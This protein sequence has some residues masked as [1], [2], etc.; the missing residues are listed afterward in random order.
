MIIEE[1]MG[2]PFPSMHCMCEECR[3]VVAPATAQDKLIAQL[4]HRFETQRKAISKGCGSTWDMLQCD[5]QIEL[6]DTAL[7]ANAQA[8]PVVSEGWP[9][10]TKE[11]SDIGW[12]LDYVFL[13]KVTKLAGSR[14]DSTTSMEATE[15][16]LIAAVELLVAASTP[17]KVQ[18]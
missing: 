8:Q 7:A 13:D 17:D 15:Q 18:P 2:C 11:C 1:K 16:V 3:P 9:K 5:E 14:T 12:T 4:R 10:A 6:I